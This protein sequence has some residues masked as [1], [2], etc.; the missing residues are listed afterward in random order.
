[1]AG[2][3]LKG[4]DDFAYF[5]KR[6]APKAELDIPVVDEALKFHGPVVILVDENSGSASELFAGVMQFKRRAVVLGTNTAGQVL[7]KSM[8]PLDDG[9]MVA[10]VTAP[11]YYPDGTRFSFNGITPDKIITDAPKDGL[12]NLAAALIA[13]QSQKV[14]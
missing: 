1:M 14:Q 13:S 6:G 5:Q 12:I 4:G 3:F 8:F 7:L 2:F 10:L 11:G 9:S